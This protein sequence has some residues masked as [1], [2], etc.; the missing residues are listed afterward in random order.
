[1]IPE[2]APLT[3]NGAKQA[4][5]GLVTACVWSVVNDRWVALALL[6]NGHSRH[7]QAAHVRL[8]DQVIPCTV[9]APVFHDPKGERLR[10]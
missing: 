2:G 10:A 1:M 4:T 5:E 9:T 6:E 3:P 8:K 7:G